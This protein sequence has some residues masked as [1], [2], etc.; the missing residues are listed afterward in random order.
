MMASNQL[1]IRLPAVCE[2]V[3]LRRSSIYGRLNPS[4]RYYDRSFP[5]PVCLSTLRNGAVAWRHDEIVAWCESRAQC[6]SH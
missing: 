4:S 5:R 3:G 1:L 6:D 2:L